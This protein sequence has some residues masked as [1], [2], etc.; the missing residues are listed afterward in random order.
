MS[1]NPVPDWENPQM[2]GQNKETAHV[3]LMP[4][5]TV[6]EAL[7][8]KHN[9]SVYYKTLNGTWKFNWVR[10][11][12]DRPMDFY[13]PDFDV[14]D[15]D[16]IPVPANWELQGHGI[17]IYVNHQ[18]EFAD[19]KAPVSKEIQFIDN[20]YP[21]NPGKVPHDYNPVG[22]Y[23]RTFTVPNNWD[24][25]QVFIQ[26]GAVKSAFYLW[27]NGQKVGYSQGSKLPA[28]FDITKYLV[29]GENIVAAEIYR[30]SDGSYLEC[31]DFWRIS[32][33]E[34]DVFIYS[35][36]KVRVRDFFAKADLDSE[37]K[38]GQFTLEVDLQ[39]HVEKFRSGNYSVEYQIFG[40]NN[41]VVSSDTQEAKINKKSN[42]KLNFS[43]EVANPKKWTAETPNLYSLVV[44][45][46]N[47]KGEIVES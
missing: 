43:K 5:R 35:T 36:P 37:Y 45:L 44:I 40:E 47:E 7:T 42:L 34:R 30:W 46:R 12:A 22:S 25:R 26:F 1:Q 2:I 10:K 6:D 41:I 4:F 3:P 32:G 16:D 39:N 27:V 33:I 38:N 29:K 18:Y 21:A 15:W 24:G 14:S 28:E 17:P 31:Q 13:K 19:Y 23:R 20:I 8:Q 11:P 9:Q